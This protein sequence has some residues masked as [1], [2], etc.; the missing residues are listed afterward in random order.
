MKWNFSHVFYTF[1]LSFGFDVSVYWLVIKII[2]ENNLFRNHNKWSKHNPAASLSKKHAHVRRFSS[3]IE[4]VTTKTHHIQKIL[5]PYRKQIACDVTN[6]TQIVTWRITKTIEDSIYDSK[7]PYQWFAAA[8]QG[9]WVW[10]VAH[11]LSIIINKK[12]DWS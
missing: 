3:Q 1:F 4:R 11:G 8:S 10:K 9:L 5:P 7:K 2:D 6:E 12:S